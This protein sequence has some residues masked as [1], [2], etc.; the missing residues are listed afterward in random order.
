MLHVCK[1]KRL[2]Y[3][4]V[5]VVSSKREKQHTSSSLTEISNGVCVCTQKFL[6]KNY[7]KYFEL[8]LIAS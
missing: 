4:V 5:Y 6:D 8:Q 3:K 1:D 7:E 2:S